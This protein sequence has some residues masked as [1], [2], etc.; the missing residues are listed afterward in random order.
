MSSF[1]GKVGREECVLVLM[2]GEGEGEGDEREQNE[3][4]GGLLRMG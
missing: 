4:G 2:G 1:D 3:E